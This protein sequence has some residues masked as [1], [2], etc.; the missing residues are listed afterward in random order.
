MPVDTL[1]YSSVPPPVPRRISV[2]ELLMFAAL[3]T[4]ILFYALFHLKSGEM[5]RSGSVPWNQFDEI[6]KEL[7]QAAPDYQNVQLHLDDPGV[8]PAADAIAFT[9]AYYTANYI[10]YPR[11]VFVGTNQDIIN[12]SDQLLAADRLPPLD[13]MHAHQITGLYVFYGA[14]LIPHLHIYRLR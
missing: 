11:R 14:Q 12:F 3:L 8:E 2:R 10:E 4:A 6:Q 5:T 13:W 7:A 9:R 1:D